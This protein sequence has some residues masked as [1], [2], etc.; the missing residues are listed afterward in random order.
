MVLQERTNVQ[1]NCF[2]PETEKL[3]KSMNAI[4]ELNNRSA[5]VKPPSSPKQRQSKLQQP[6]RSSSRGRS[7]RHA[8]PPLRCETT[9]DA[10]HAADHP[11]ADGK[12]SSSAALGLVLLALLVLATGACAALLAALLF[13]AISPLTTAPPGLPLSLEPPCEQPPQPTEWL[14]LPEP[15]ECHFNL[16]WSGIRCEPSFHC[17]TALKWRPL[18]HP[19]CRMR[20]D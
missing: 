17:R 1:D 15:P 5:S 8:T 7:R 13:G 18:P 2:S 9:C 6:A 20:N 19:T 14:A 12:S 16:R 11:Q 3:F 4:Y 10:N